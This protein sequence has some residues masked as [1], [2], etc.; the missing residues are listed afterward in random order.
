M[1]APKTIQQQQQMQNADGKVNQFKFLDLNWK[2]HLK[3]LDLV[4]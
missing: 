2:P 4:S 1:R 3:V